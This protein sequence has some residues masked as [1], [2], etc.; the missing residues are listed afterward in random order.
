MVE[1]ENSSSM[2]VST[3]SG[4]VSASSSGNQ[5]Q[6]TQQAGGGPPRRKRNLPGMPGEL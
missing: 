1:L 6:G 4:E 3:A 5:I 2:A